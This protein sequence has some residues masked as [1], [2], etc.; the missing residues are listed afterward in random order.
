MNPR[1]Q[2]A[3]ENPI[4]KVGMST[5]DVV[6]LVPNL[7]W[8][9][10]INEKIQWAFLQIVELDNDDDSTIPCWHTSIT[11]EV[12][13]DL[14]PLSLSE[15]RSNSLLKAKDLLSLTMEGVGGLS[16]PSIFCWARGSLHCW[17]NCTHAEAVI[18]W[19]N[20]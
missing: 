7:R 12:I 3:L 4:P 18:A 10:V 2:L 5:Q 20:S 16:A 17:V 14:E 1:Q 19:R 8:T 15:W 13:P 6:H 11:I 9:V